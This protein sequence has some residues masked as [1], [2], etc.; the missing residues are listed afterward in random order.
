MLNDFR[1]VEWYLSYCP[2]P[3]SRRE[4][5]VPFPAFLSVR[6]TYAASM[7][8]ASVSGSKCTCSCY[9][10]RDGFHPRWYLL[11]SNIL[12]LCSMLNIGLLLLLPLLQKLADFTNGFKGW[13]VVTFAVNAFEDFSCF[14]SLTVYTTYLICF[15]A[16]VPSV[17]M[18]DTIPVVSGAPL[19]AVL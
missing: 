12:G 19:R 14:S 15:S 6:E 3:C 9:F 2:G 10:I 17:Y 16:M 8:K 7:L 4:L 5:L 13:R 11:I 18:Q 1:E